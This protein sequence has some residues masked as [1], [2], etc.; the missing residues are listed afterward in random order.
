MMINEIETKQVP[1][2]P[3]AA[4]KPLERILFIMLLSLAVF[5]VL[6]LTTVVG[7]QAVYSGRIY[8]GITVG[9][10]PVGGLNPDEAKLVLS[11]Q[12][13]YP[14]TGKITFVD[15]DRSWEYSPMDLGFLL[16]TNASIDQAFA[17]GRTSLVERLKTQYNTFINGME[18]AP[19]YVYDQ[20]ITS[21]V[22]E[23][24][25][26]ETDLETIEATLKIENA[27]VVTTLGQNGRKLNVEA[28]IDGILPYLSAYRNVT[29]ALPIEDRPAGIVDASEQ[30]VIAQEALN[31]DFTILKP[32][33]SADGPWI[34]SKEF[35]ASM[36]T[37]NRVDD[38]N[39]PRYELGLE[40]D[41][42]VEF[43]ATWAPGLS[44][45]PENARFIFNDDTGKLDLAKSATIGRAV[46]AEMTIQAIEAALLQGK[47]SS[48]I[49]FEY[50]EPPVTDDTTGEELGIVELVHAETS[51]F[52]GSDHAR[53]QN[54]QTSAAEFHGLLI[55]PNTTFSMA[56]AMDDVTLDNG[57]AEAWIIYGDQ[58]IKGVGG[59]V[60]QVSTTFFRAA[61]FAG[62]PI[63][64]RHPHAYRV[65][66][67]ERVYGG[68]I[69]P[70]LTGLDATVYLP[71]V[72]F[73]FTNDSDQWLLVETYVV[74]S[75]SA[76]TFK[77]Y[78]TKQN[79][80]LDWSTTGLTDIEPEP[81]AIYRYNPDLDEGQIKQVDW[82]KDGGK[83][84]IFRTV[85][86]DGNYEFDDTFYT[87]FQAWRDI[88]E[89]GPNTELPEDANVEGEEN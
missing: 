34:I 70:N 14:I 39:G 5:F 17:Y 52:Y 37:L 43:I 46:D 36:L 88:Y 55:P 48:S 56:E 89:F 69:D 60:C 22:L 33:D 59:G 25:R 54:I 73:K 53:V 83:V 71:V 49:D 62:F 74:P 3:P 7:F 30:A 81:E 75:S 2:F 42:I 66:Y 6:T 8:P 78:G 40:R 68:G 57:Y 32:N 15:G 51:Y 65:S 44:Q 85:Y 84:T 13:N 45:E 1:T 29:I 23:E 21:T 35:L 9:G 10:I 4:P 20:R 76:I 64:E 24:M 72:D 28:T 58:T 38:E 18:F 11:T 79:R 86:K 31:Q 50:N 41:P 27:Q 82:G 80:T 26:A 61:F 77:F 63:V 19:V 87:N 47:H 16:D 12:L 67:Y